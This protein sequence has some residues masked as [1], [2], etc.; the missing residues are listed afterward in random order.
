MDNL[1]LAFSVVFPL[2][3]MML[4]GYVIRQ[5]NMVDDKSLKVFNN[6]TFRVFLP[7]LLFMNVYQ[8]NI[9]EVLNPKLLIFGI[10]TVLIV[11]A[12]LFLII[13]VIE[14]DKSKIG[15][16]I[17][18]IFRSNFILFGLPVTVSLFGE[19]NTGVVSVL[20]AIIVPMYNFISVIVL[21]IF[22]G[23]KK[24]DFKKIIKGI[25]T[26]PLIVASVAAIVILSLN[27][28]L[29]QIITK[30]MSDI[31]K[32][33]TPLSLMILGGTFDFSQ[34]SGNVRN[35]I[36]CVLGKLVIVPSIVIPIAVM[37]GFRG[38]ELGALL[39]MVGAP[40]AVS[41]FTMAQQMDGDSV[42]AGQVVVV[43]TAACIF[44]IFLWVFILKQ[45]SLI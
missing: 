19:E 36:I 39:T 5:I 16:M 22:R 9:E 3:V 30:P 33:A 4:V 8:T 43:T 10:L 25:V 38:I 1:Y 13:P 40:T 20:I 2:F 21:E 12:V 24:I 23:S 11:T 28:K 42:L 41:S 31:S 35:L 27:I 17:Q 15:V 26:N 34:L 29:P 14:K 6:V 45:M 32:I 44:T 7:C 37:M 18:G